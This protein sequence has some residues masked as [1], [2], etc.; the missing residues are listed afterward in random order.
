[1]HGDILVIFLLGLTTNVVIFLPLKGKTRAH[2]ALKYPH[3][4]TWEGWRVGGVYI[5]GTIL[6][7]NVTTN[8]L[9]K[10]YQPRKQTRRSKQ[11]HKI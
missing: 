3:F 9:S 10:K 6:G 8:A 5:G 1:M 4:A 7:R 2:E 11:L